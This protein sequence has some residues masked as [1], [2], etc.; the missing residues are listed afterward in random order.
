MS[1]KLRS[2]LWYDR[3]P[4]P[5]LKRWA[6]SQLAPHAT[7]VRWTYTVPKG[8][9]AFLEFMM[10]RVYRY[11]AADVVGGVNSM[12]RVT[13]KDGSATLLVVASI[14]VG[15]NVAGDRELIVVG[16]SMLLFSESKIEGVSFVTGTGGTT[17][18]IIVAKFTEFDA[19]PIEIPAFP[20][21]MPIT[22]IQQRP[23]RDPRM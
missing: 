23:P 10:C 20:S 21:E 15:D 22:D 2:T 7:T 12:I 6:G 14:S 9:N 5:I 3:N 4:K 8:R 1:F 17:D 18:H 16:Q 13:P 19:F 11:S